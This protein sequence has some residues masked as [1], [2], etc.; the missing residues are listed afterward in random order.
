MSTESTT[1]K[2]PAVILVIGMAGS[3]KTTFLQRL[4]AHLHSKKQP[5]YILNLDPAVRN[6]PYGA[7]IDIRDTVDYREVMKQYNLGPNGGILTSLNLFTTKFDQVLGLVNKRA[8]SVD[9]ILLD[10][11]GQ[12]EIFTWSASGSIITDAL[13]SQYPTM[14]A[15]IIDTPRTQSPATFM[16]NMLYACSILYK[17]KL[18]MVLVFN[19][20]DVEMPEDEEGRGGFEKV[21]EWMSDW[22]SFQAAL[23]EDEETLGGTGGTGGSGY[24]NSLINSM[25]LMLEEFYRHLDVVGVSAVTGQGFND[26]L[27]AVQNKVEEYNKEYKP[28]LEA[29]M[30]ERESKKE[31]SKENSLARLMKDMKMDRSGITSAPQEG[32]LA[33]TISDVED[34]DEDVDEDDVYDGQLGD[35]DLVPDISGPGVGMKH[36]ER[37]GQSSGQGARGGRGKDFSKEIL[38]AMQR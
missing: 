22:E 13:A 21:K 33:E 28:E 23:R 31:K 16:S 34:N 4:N 20:C 14:I 27:E 29:L 26:F 15:Y 38:E 19:K 6:V 24:M 10:T 9:H 36:D 7:N 18:P 17:T 12:I 3:G 8:A 32:G 37:W 25:S 2:Q 30:K 1:E 11:P 35:E 5:P